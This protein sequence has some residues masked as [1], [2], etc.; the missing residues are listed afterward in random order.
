MDAT[1]K[2]EAR[3]ME[4]KR[5]RKNSTKKIRMIAEKAVRIASFTLYDHF[6]PQPVEMTADELEKTLSDGVKVRDDRLTV[7]I[8]RNTATLRAHS[9]SWLEIYLTD[10]K[11]F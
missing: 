2:E 1:Q 4:I 7:N 3:K 10:C 9:N 5:I 11:G 6:I 8:D